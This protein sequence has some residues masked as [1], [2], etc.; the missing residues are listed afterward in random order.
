M[1]DST[2]T[3]D[4]DLLHASSPRHSKTKDGISYVYVDYDSADVYVKSPGN[5]FVSQGVTVTQNKS[6]LSLDLSKRSDDENEKFAEIFQ[7]IDDY[8][9]QRAVASG[10]KW[11]GKDVTEES[12]REMFQPSL[13][14]NKLQLKLSKK[15]QVETQVFSNETKEQLDASKFLAPGSLQNSLVRFVAILDGVYIDSTAGFF[16]PVWYARQLMVS[17]DTQHNPFG[18]EYVFL[19]DD[20]YD[21]LED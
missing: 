7:R 5:I 9:L 2:K 20:S 16:K 14:E 12:A 6:T 18:H 11:F 15:G 21:S 13:S 10:Q 8:L 17:K 1:L 3:V 19:D 4:S